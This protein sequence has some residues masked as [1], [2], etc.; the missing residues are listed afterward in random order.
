MKGFVACVFDKCPKGSAML[1]RMTVLIMTL[2]GLKHR[3]L[4][5]QTHKLITNKV[6]SCQCILL[7]NLQVCCLL[8]CGCD[9]LAAVYSLA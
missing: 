5:I 8:G 1:Q 6:S 7:S 2:S 4:S 9:G 3:G